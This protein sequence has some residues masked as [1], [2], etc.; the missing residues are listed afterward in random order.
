MSTASDFL[1]RSLPRFA[2]RTRALTS[3]LLLVGV[4]ASSVLS[5]A[6]NPNSPLVVRVTDNVV[7]PDPQPYGL[8]QLAGR[9]A[10][11]SLSDNPLAN[12]FEPVEVRDR[13][14]AQSTGTTADNRSWFSHG[15]F[16][17]TNSGD[18]YWDGAAIRAY[19]PALQPDGYWVYQL[20]GEAEVQQSMVDRGFWR[21]SF[22]YT[23]LSYT[24]SDGAGGSRSINL[25][26]TLLGNVTEFTDGRVSEWYNQTDL[27]N[28]QIYY[29]TV[30]AVDVGGN[31]SADLQVVSATP[32]AGLQGGPYFLR[33]MA[34]PVANGATSFSVDLE[35][36]NGTPPYQVQVLNSSLPAGFEIVPVTVNQRAMFRLRL[37]SGVTAGPTHT[38]A[39]TL[40]SLRLTDAVARSSDHTL[41]L[42]PAATG[43]DGSDNTAPQP[44]QN[45]QAEPMD[46]AVRL[47]WNPSPSP[48]VIGYRVY[49][50]KWAPADQLGRVE[51]DRQLN[52]Q[53]N[54]LIFATKVFSSNALKGD[55]SIYHDRVLF[56]AFTNDP[57]WPTWRRTGGSTLEPRSARNL[58]FDPD[59]RI[60][61][62]PHPGVLPE[63]F[64]FPGTQ[65][66]KVS[67]P[68]T[69]WDFWSVRLF[70]TNS[71]PNQ[72]E[73][74]YR[75]LEPG[76]TYHF[77]V[78]VYQ[79]GVP[80]GSIQINVS[81]HTQSSALQ[82][83]FA[84][85]EGQWVQLQI[86]NW[87]PTVWDANAAVEFITLQANGGG[88][89]YIDA[90]ELYE[91]RDADNDGL[92]DF[93]PREMLP[94]WKD[95]L[96]AFYQTPDGKRGT[97]RYWGLQ[98]NGARGTSLDQ[99][100]KPVLERRRTGSQDHMSLG[101]FLEL[102][103]EVGADPWIIASVSL[104]PAEYAGI[105]EY[106]AG[107]LSTPYGALRI[108]HRGGNPT[109]WI[110]EFEHIHWEVDNEVWNSM[111]SWVFQSATDY[112][113]F[114]EMLLRAVTGSPLWQSAP[115]F[116]DQ[117][118]TFVVNGFNGN[119]NFG[120]EA[121]LAA[122]TAEMVD[123]A[124]YLGGWE[125]GNYI[126]GSTL[127]EEG[128]AKWLVYSPWKHYG[129]VNGHVERQAAAAALRPQP[130]VLGVYEGGPGYDLP[131]P[132]NPSNPVA[133]SYG[134][135]LAAAITTLD[136]YLFES[137]RGYGAQ[138][139]FGFQ[140]GTRWTTH[141]MG[142]NPNTNAMEFLA[143]GTWLA[144]QLRNNFATG[145]LV[146]NLIFSTPTVD[147]PAEAGQP[148]QP[149]VP[150]VAVYSFRDEDQY[151]V[152]LM[153]R[154]MPL[155]DGN[156]AIIDPAITPVTLHLPITSAARIR[157]HKIEND[158]RR[159]NVRGLDFFDEN[160]PLRI[161]SSTL[162]S[163]ALGSDGT[164]VFRAADGA[165]A[166]AD[167][168]SHGIA[169]GSIYLFV[170]EGPQRVPLP[171]GPVVSVQR[172][173]GQ[174]ISTFTQNA[175]FQVLFDRPM[176]PLQLAHLDF[177]RSTADL[178]NALITL[179]VADPWLPQT[180]RYIVNVNGVTSGGVVQLDL[181]AGR[182]FALDGGT[183]N[184]AADG[185]D[186]TVTLIQ[187]NLVLNFN[188]YDLPFGA[189]NDTPR[190]LEGS[191]QRQD[192]WYSL[193]LNTRLFN[194]TG[195]AAVYG[196]IRAT[197]NGGLSNASN[198]V[199]LTTLITNREGNSGWPQ[200]S[201]A[202]FNSNG[203]DGRTVTSWSIFLFK[204]EDFSGIAANDPFGLNSGSELRVEMKSWTGTQR[205]MHFVIQDSGQFFVSESTYSGEE[206]WTLN[207]FVDNP[208][209]RWA[210]LAMTLGGNDFSTAIENAPN[211]VYSPRSFNNVE[212][213]GFAA[214]VQ[215]PFN[216]N[217]HFRRF[218]LTS[219]TDYRP[220]I[221]YDLSA[222]STLLQPEVWTN[223][224]ASAIDADTPTL[225]VE[226]S[227]LS[228]PPGAITS[229][230]SGPT[231]T[232]AA[233]AMAQNRFKADLPGSYEL[234][235]RFDDGDNSVS[236]RVLTIQVLGPETEKQSYGAWVAS[237]D[238][239]EASSAWDADPDGDG[240][241]NLL[242]FA[243][244]RNPLLPEPA[245]YATP[246]LQMENGH[247]GITFSY[248]AGLNLVYRVVYS[249]NLN[250]WTTLYS[251]AHQNLPSGP[252]TVFLDS[253]PPQ[254]QADFLR[255]EIEELSP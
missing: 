76:K 187:G 62:V 152:L 27:D 182:V 5:G 160:N 132:S 104:S 248:F 209:N 244:G 115:E 142:I 184:L 32:Q 204:R 141:S 161:V 56:E 134:K 186:Q 177:S 144:Q 154:K 18:G 59:F 236:S 73:W 98:S 199:I 128:F 159:T 234:Q 207:N 93:P 99:Q 45:V 146:E 10:F 230:E 127:T 54:D 69:G 218:T 85:P 214:R 172:D 238:W 130:Y 167:G 61:F 50:S 188:V 124:P 200:A 95:Q 13:W 155:F 109:P 245:G 224:S 216:R 92:N 64:Q 137:Y 60:E 179:S 157:L 57:L 165:V 101:E 240:L 6:A 180:L 17:S 249:P 40:V 149:D 253:P 193:N 135:S 156:G 37:A 252:I 150:L 176:T 80:N 174:P 166:S 105:L 129:Q 122:P 79:V 84:V 123:L 20:L 168:L 222:S 116:F 16:A 125:A 175:R 178:S 225:Q 237:I 205:R 206:A 78:W 118:I 46:G 97:F 246:T 189:R 28:G 111:F 39:N 151:A 223:L 43:L 34:G 89:V 239:Q 1:D 192:A 100:L 233:G 211:L 72:T 81:S 19:R 33:T 121:A 24:V 91:F 181:P 169:A 82:R 126:G 74:F 227:I 163:S 201:Y 185:G 77:R 228:A 148:A 65:C 131:G 63:G 23:N 196:G 139:F 7:A 108:Q 106:L 11:N 53:P 52:L 119:R 112:G 250:Q 49:R 88:T 42:N 208:A 87:Q 75:A 198:S 110:E 58:A 51:L 133:E 113:R 107:D 66:V 242:E 12:G 29:Y 38:A 153:S 15:R 215:D 41:L 26:D 251:T 120:Y 226:W 254:G 197:V 143:Q 55:K 235:A 44:P 138:A 8:N 2:G 90:A 96:K 3:T 30:R 219:V 83:Q 21:V 136:S 117:K 35:V 22:N 213:V 158:P 183:P 171:A 232:V 67:S 145:G 86:N 231:T 31:E 102:C 170:F 25:R 202:G 164:F 114:A 4:L 255:I 220:Y 212:A 243:F 194:H 162:S 48:D 9:W 191:D 47:T 203:Q 147:L 221:Q 68:N 229:L 70:T 36:A 173:L 210:P 140:P 71:L 14:F 241:S 195:T 217:R 190:T 247:L 103:L 94:F